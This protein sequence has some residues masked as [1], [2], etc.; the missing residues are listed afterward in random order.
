MLWQNESLNHTKNFNQSNPSQITIVHQIDDLP[1][2]HLILS[3]FQRKIDFPRLVHHCFISPNS[4]LHRVHTVFFR[5]RPLSF[6]DY[7]LYRNVISL[8]FNKMI[9]INFPY[10]EK[11]TIVSLSASPLLKVWSFKNL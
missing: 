5:F 7:T 1:S 11:D 6:V 10:G 4:F 3:Y 8:T 9:N 2:R